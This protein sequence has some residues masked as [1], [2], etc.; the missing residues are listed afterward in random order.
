MFKLNRRLGIFLT[1]LF[2]R[3]AVRAVFFIAGVNT[4]YTGLEL[5]ATWGLS[6]AALPLYCLFLFIV[7]WCFRLAPAPN[8]TQRDK[9]QSTPK[10]GIDPAEVTAVIDKALQMIEEA[11]QKRFFSPE[12]KRERPSD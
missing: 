9:T 2:N 5:W 11:K 7:C 1:H 4:I 3:P 6:M 10:S 12:E 8:S